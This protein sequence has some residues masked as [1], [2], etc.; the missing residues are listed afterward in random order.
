MAAG[1]DIVMLKKNKR[2][3]VSKQ[4]WIRRTRFLLG[5][6]K[7]EAKISWTHATKG[8]EDDVVYGIWKGE[9]N[10]LQWPA[11]ADTEWGRL[12]DAMNAMRLTNEHLNR[13]S[14][15][16]NR[17]ASEVSAIELA[18]DDWGEFNLAG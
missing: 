5:K 7:A 17:A 14:S 10:V 11:K 13:A 12:T 9:L 3:L 4:E 2:F 1:R 15:V 18:G 16:M 8:I 6:S